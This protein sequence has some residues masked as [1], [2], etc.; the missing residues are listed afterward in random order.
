MPAAEL[1]FAE[2]TMAATAGLLGGLGHCSGMCG[3]IVAAF[4]ID[5]PGV[6]GAVPVAPLVF[7]NAGRV[8][9]YTLLGAM[10][11]GLGSF[12]GVVAPLEGAQYALMAATGLL[13]FFMGLS[14]AGAIRRA[15]HMIERHNSIVLRAA[16]DVLTAKSSIKYLPLG[17]VLGMLPCG[18]SYTML[19][20]AS[21]SGGFV[22]GAARMLA[23]GLGTVP[24]MFLIGVLAGRLGHILRGRLY[25]AGG[26]VVALMGLLYVYRGVS[27]YVRM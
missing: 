8:I 22:Q 4:T 27:F 9:T 24:A 23:F 12:V 19:I 14:I 26:A 6:G 10:V 2:F 13:M 3:P 17:L 7:Y 11:G 1:Q 18:L 25:R 20:G 5:R 15:T 21:G 16:R